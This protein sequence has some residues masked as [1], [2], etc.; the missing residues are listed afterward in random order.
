MDQRK[1]SCHSISSWDNKTK[2]Y[3]HS[4]LSELNLL[5]LLVVFVEHAFWV[6]NIDFPS[7]LQIHEL[8]SSGTLLLGS[9]IV[10]TFLIN[11]DRTEKIDATDASSKIGVA[12]IKNEKNQ[13]NHKLWSRISDKEKNIQQ[14]SQV[15]KAF[16]D[17]FLTYQLRWLQP[18]RRMRENAFSWYWILL[19]LL[20][21]S[22]F[23]LIFYLRSVP[24]NN[25][26]SLIE[27]GRSTNHKHPRVVD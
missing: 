25:N 4:G 15:V 17:D 21:T 22:A 7:W 26:G 23:K 8:Q 9:Q 20:E 1:I 27:L 13:L 18:T 6:Q 5:P 3:S 10:F 11:S 2:W 14:Q 12:S 24:L 19:I 16:V